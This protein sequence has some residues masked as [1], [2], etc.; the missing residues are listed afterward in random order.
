ME[1]ALK[2][3]GRNR[4]ATLMLRFLPGKACPRVIIV[5][6]FPSD[7]IELERI[8][9]E[10]LGDKTTLCTDTIDCGKMSAGNYDGFSSL[11][12]RLEGEN[13]DMVILANF[14]GREKREWPQDLLESLA[15]QVPLV[16]VL[17]KRTRGRG[18][19]SKSPSFKGPQVNPHYDSCSFRLAGVHLHG[20]TGLISRFL[21]LLERVFV[22]DTYLEQLFGRLE[23]N[24]YSRRLNISTP[25]ACGV[26]GGQDIKKSYFIP[27]FNFYKCRTCGSLFTKKIFQPESNFCYYQREWDKTSYDAYYSS[28]RF[29][30]AE[31]IIKQLARFKWLRNILDI[32]CGRGF[33][34]FKAMEYG[35]SVEG[36]D[37]SLPEEQSRLVPEKM[38]ELYI[39][40]KISEGVKYDCLSFHGVLEHINDYDSFLGFCRELLKSPGLILFSIPLLEGPLYSI[41]E[42]LYRF[43]CG[44]VKTPWLTLLQWHSSSPHIF[45]PT[46]GGVRH[47]LNS[48]FIVKSIDSFRQPMIDRARILHRVRLEC[49]SYDQGLF[50][51]ILL[52]ALGI[53][54]I[55]ID[56]IS[57]KCNL[58][59]EAFFIAQIVDQSND[60][61]SDSN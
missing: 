29:V 42:K 48:H 53:I 36:I 4:L 50:K 49:K 21:F 61:N 44:I 26:C 45:L 41:C 58:I 16:A 23:V 24:L 12:K 43:S 17:G 6:G 56:W 31:L 14:D 9:M 34:V 7:R 27:P 5:S 11:L 35:Y 32:G 57:D 46:K 2:D 18:D 52:Y 10:K 15:L 22:V 13:P 20:N 30:Q 3:F 25:S 28:L 60:P 1:P 33:F 54:A 37:V 40:Q 59:N 8:L 47:L 19:S 38:R 55:V 51:N 39:E